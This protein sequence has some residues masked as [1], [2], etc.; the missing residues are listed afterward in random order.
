MSACLIFGP[1]V[2]VSVP[3]VTLPPSH[4]L[5]LCLSALLSSAPH[6]GG[7]SPEWPPSHYDVQYNNSTPCTGLI[8]V[9]L[10]AMRGLC[11]SFSMTAAHTYLPFYFEA[12]LMGWQPWH[13]CRHCGTCYYGYINIL[14][15]TWLAIEEIITCHHST[16]KKER[17]LFYACAHAHTFTFRKRDLF[18]SHSSLSN[19]EFNSGTSYLE[20][21]LL[22]LIMYCISQNPRK[23]T[24]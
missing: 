13:A 2:L 1:T 8:F 14:I 4:P 3:S 16:A 6:S 24:L 22:K 9:Y 7:G 21:T 12:W 20:S 23:K 17:T 18:S 19:N 11:L 5:S 15:N 10:G